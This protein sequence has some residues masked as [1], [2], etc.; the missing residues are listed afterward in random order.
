MNWFFKGL[1][2][3]FFVLFTLGAI[4]QYNDPDALVWIIIYG[5]AGIISLLFTLEKLKKVVPLILGIICFVGFIYL[6]PPNFQG[7][8]LN[9]GANETIELGREAFGLLIISMVFLLYAFILRK[10]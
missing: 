10:N 1:G 8:S 5:L 7:F 6:Y 3:F 4:V 9:D 2:V